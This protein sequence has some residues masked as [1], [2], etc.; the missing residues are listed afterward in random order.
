[1]LEELKSEVAA[2]SAAIAALGET[3]STETAQIG[4]KVSGLEATIARLEEQLA[5]G[6]T[7]DISAELAELKANTAAIAEASAR[8]SAIVPDEV[9]VQP[10]E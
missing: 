3:L 1:M 10:V 7:P 4:E 5:N 2:N 6:Q 8:I 9:V